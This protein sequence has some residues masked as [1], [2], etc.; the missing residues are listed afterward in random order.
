MKDLKFGSTEEALQHLSD[1]TGKRVKIA[2]GETIPYVTEKTLANPEDYPN[3]EIRD[4][5]MDKKVSPRSINSLA[6]AGINTVD[7]LKKISP[8]DLSI[9]KNVNKRAAEEIMKVAMGLIWSK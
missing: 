3:F 9:M 6:H 5:L 8:A 1:L 7:A 2:V 4:M